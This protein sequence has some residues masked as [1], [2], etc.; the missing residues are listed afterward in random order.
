MGGQTTTIRP[1]AP[2]AL[3]CGSASCTVPYSPSMLTR[4]ISWKRF[5]GVRSTDA[6]QIA[7]EL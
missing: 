4:C 7:P 5:I 2:F 3:R 1:C 6:H